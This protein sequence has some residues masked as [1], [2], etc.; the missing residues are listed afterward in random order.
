MNLIRTLTTFVQV[1]DFK[2]VQRRVY[3]ALN[4]LNALGIVEKKRNNIVY[5]GEMEPERPDNQELVQLMVKLSQTIL[6]ELIFVEP[7][8]SFSLIFTLLQIMLKVYSI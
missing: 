5:K 1:E 6:P 7:S 8:I 4:V 2:N 3:D